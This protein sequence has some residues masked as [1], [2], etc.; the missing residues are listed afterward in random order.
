MKA[1][2]PKRTP[3]PYDPAQD[4][5]ADSHTETSQR[6]PNVYH[7]FAPGAVASHSPQGD[8]TLAI[9]TTGGM[10]LLVH[11][12]APKVWRIRYAKATPVPQSYALAPDYAPVP[13][14]ATIVE[15]D[16]WLDIN[17]ESVTCRIYKAD[18]RVAFLD[19]A[20]HSVILQESAPHHERATLLDGTNQVM[21]SFEAPKSEVYFGLGD[22]SWNLNLRGRHFNNW[23]SDAFGFHKELD[24]LYRAIPFYYG[25][26]EGRA[27]GVFF[28]NTWRTH[29][30]FDSHRD[31]TVR[32][33]A[34]GGEM[35]YYFCY[36][37]S[38]DE[39]ATAYH[40]L[41]GKPELPPLWTLG[42]HQCRWSYY[43]ES[44]VRQLAQT[45]R[46]LEIPCDAIYLDIDYMDGY[47]C[48]TWNKDYFPDPKRMI[49]DLAEQGFQTIVM[50]DPGIRVDEDYPVYTTG[51]EQDVFCRRTSGELMRGPVWP[52]DC[53][54]PD[55][56]RH[57]VRQWWG[58]LYRGL[59]NEQGVAGFWN[60][61][62]EPAVFKVHH[63]TF[64]DAVMHGN[65][66]HP[67][68][69]RSA[70]NIYGQQMSRGTFEGLKALQPTK[71]PFVLTRATF[72]GGQRYA[73]VWT[74]DNVASWDHLRMANRQCQ[75]L[76]ISGF[77]LVGT[78][79]GGFVDQPTGEL[80]VRWLQLGVFHPVFRVHSMGNN[81]DGA[82]EADWD[83]IKA[84]ES[85]NRLD[86]EPWVFGEPYTAQAR[87]A[88][89]FR[90][91]LLPY[92]YST[93]YQHT[94]T[95][96][97]VI[98]SLSFADSTDA[99][100]LKREQ[101]F[102]LGQHLLVSPVME[103]GA[104][105]HTT[106]LPQ[107]DWCD[108]Y[109]GKLHAGGRTHRQR[110]TPNSIPLYVRAGAVLPNYPVQ[111]H[112]HEQPIDAA[113]LRAYFGKPTT[114]SQLY[115]DAGDGYGY[116]QGDYALHTFTTEGSDA[117][118]AI[119]QTTTGRYTGDLEVFEIKLFNLP[120]RP[121]QL[122]IDGE[123]IQVIDEE[124][125]AYVVVAPADYQR[126]EVRW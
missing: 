102:L 88:I 49:G 123:A 113:E 16:E 40:T 23:N 74:G 114:E 101:E 48:F 110:V 5:V 17:T 125:H 81:V 36:G 59:Y 112:V 60:D 85:T 95:G 9:R 53:V 72:S 84:A 55:Y 86:Q 126:V 93:L 7:D 91:K 41:T 120:A 105:S 66:G 94:L 62:N 69:H 46:D 82:S 75:R 19:A 12:G 111:Q 61:M 115:R 37:P 18:C 11:W 26:R 30:D 70:H 83:A 73:A 79:I 107:G 50:I 76:S 97:P 108:Y 54:W 51:I 71:R 52:P 1:K 24:P 65:D 124:A 58:Q 21:A 104:A 67:A 92:L 8:Q 25:V 39:V 116:Q 96:L 56:T 98:R 118:F 87:E 45:F 13:T 22:K 78:D 4:W 2:Q 80:M 109:T 43:P 57:D 14:K 47:R 31:Q 10:T 122:W 44:R 33:W 28:H 106:Y 32:M 15:T 3:R 68:D 103:A 38:L 20:T 117:H 63:L 35:D 64:P 89:S 119:T 121:E 6:Y 29:F 90:Y 99:K 34:E 100:A 77:S 27:Y 42:F